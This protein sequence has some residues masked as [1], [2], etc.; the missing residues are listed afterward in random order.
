MIELYPAIDL[1]DGRCVRLQQG[2]FDR[3][4]VYDADP[5]AVART[6]AEAGAPW[7]HVVDLDAAR[8]GEPVNR[9]IVEAIA[10]AVAATGAHVQAGGGVRTAEDA[11]RLT[12]AGVHRVVMGTAALRDPSLVEAASRVASVAVGLDHR[13]GELAIHGWTDASGVQLNDAVGW[14]P[15]AAAFVVTDIGRDGTLL[16]PDV[17]GLRDLSGRTPVPLIASGGVSSLADLAALA[18]LAIA[19]VITG[20]AL[21]EARFTI[22]EALRALAR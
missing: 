3:E 13:R 20:K 18:S 14:F 16:G 22:A 8:R 11:A 10:R 6:F 5:V 2:D 17:D 4:T 9:P 1:R 15:T 7:I 19:G 12:D 21:Y